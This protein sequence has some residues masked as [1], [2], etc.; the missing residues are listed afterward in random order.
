ME[1]GSVIIQVRCALLY[2]FNKR[3]RLDVAKYLDDPEE[4]PVVI[5]NQDEFQ[6]ALTMAKQP[7]QS[8]RSAPAK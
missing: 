4:T 6:R 5:A 2:H 7:D 1:K 8:R 3:L